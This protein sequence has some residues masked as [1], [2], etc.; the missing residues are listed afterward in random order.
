VASAPPARHATGAKR[1]VVQVATFQTET[2][3]DK[4]SAA[5]TAKGAVDLKVVRDRDGAGNDL[6]AI[7]TGDFPTE[8]A[9]QTAAQR[10]RATGAFDSRVVH[11]SGASEA[12]TPD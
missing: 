8:E 4:V 6:Y 9:A 5:L 1:I 10:L 3:A 2:M 12:V 11:L 7:R